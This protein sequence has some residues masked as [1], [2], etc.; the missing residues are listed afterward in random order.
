M[1]PGAAHPDQE[2]QKLHVTSMI[3]VKTDLSRLTDE[4]FIAKVDLIVN[5]MT[6]NANFTTPTSQRSGIFLD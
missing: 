6:G 5:S 1:G 4:E 2:N 3:K